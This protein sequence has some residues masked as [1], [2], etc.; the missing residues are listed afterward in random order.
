MFK[1]L[2]LILLRRAGKEWLCRAE[3]GAYCEGSNTCRGNTRDRTGVVKSLLPINQPPHRLPRGGMGKMDVSGEIIPSPPTQAIIPLGLA[4]PLGCGEGNKKRAWVR[5]LWDRRQKT[6]HTHAMR[7]HVRTQ[8]E[9]LLITPS[10][11]IVWQERWGL[12]GK[13][14]V[15]ILL[16][17]QNRLRSR[18]ELEAYVL[19]ELKW[20]TTHICQVQSM[21]LWGICMNL[22]ILTTT[23]Q[24]RCSYLH[25]SHEA[26]EPQEAKLLAY[27]HTIRMWQGW[28]SDQWWAECWPPTMA[29]ISGMIFS[30]SLPPAWGLSRSWTIW[31]MTVNFLMSLSNL[32]PKRKDYISP[33]STWLSFKHSHLRELEY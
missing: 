19:E 12:H 30:F 24:W 16:D 23:V 18:K 27:D 9:P 6:G 26:P 25:C 11:L 17:N 28:D 22:S 32:D 1:H 20:Q 8:W 29:G 2:T 31:A 33:Y 21:S 13:A 14:Y 4:T 5:I 10:G 15:N 3:P 7:S